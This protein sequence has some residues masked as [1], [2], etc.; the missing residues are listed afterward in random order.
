MALAQI[1]FAD[2]YE[3]TLHVAFDENGLMNI[4]QYTDDTLEPGNE[5]LNGTRSLYRWNICETYYT[6]YHYTA[7]TWIL[8][9]HSAQNPTCQKVDV[10][11]VFV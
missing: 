3:E 1:S 11:R 8:G 9:K 5:Y 2:E 10:K 7:L 4:Q 6:G